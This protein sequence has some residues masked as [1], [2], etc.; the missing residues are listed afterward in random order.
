MSE[1][2]IRNFGNDTVVQSINELKGALMN[3][4]QGQHVSIVFTRP[5]GLKKI[6]FVSV[7][8]SVVRDTYSNEIVDFDA[9]SKEIYGA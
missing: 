6:I 1:I 2:T 4:Y 8:D 3:N 5:S 7:T 9:V